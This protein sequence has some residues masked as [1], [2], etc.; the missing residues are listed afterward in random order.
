MKDA[1][2]KPDTQ[3][4]VVAE[5]FPHAPEAIWKALT[6]GELIARWLKMPTTGF[7]PVKGKHFTFQT[8][9]AGSWDG[10]IYCQLLEGDAERAPRLFLERRTRGKRRLWLTPGHS[11]NVDPVNGRE[12]NAPSSCPFRLR[13]AEERYCF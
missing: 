9:P 10:V 12:R 4:I 8:T 5:V 11:R 6:T 3:D 1:A 2:L 13:A 7:E